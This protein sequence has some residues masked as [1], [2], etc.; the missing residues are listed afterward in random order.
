MKCPGCHSD[1]ADTSQF[2]SRCGAPLA[3]DGSVP[4]PRAR[5]LDPPP[6]TPRAD[7]L[8]AGKYRVLEEIGRGGMGVV[9]KAEDI[10]LKRPVALKFLPPQLADW[11]EFRERFLIEAQ[12]A[13]ALSHP[14]TCVIHEV[15]ETEERPFLAMEYVEGETLDA[16]IKRG[17]LEGKDIVAIIRQVAAGLGD[18]HRKGIVHRDIKSSNIMVTSDGQAKIMD[19]GLAK[20]RGG[21]AL[22]K[23]HTTLGT[24]TY[25]SPEQACGDEVDHRTDLWSA[26]VVLYEMLTGELPFQ[27]ESEVGV[28][29]RIVYEDP[30]PIRHRTPPVPSE[31]QQVVARA[32]KKNREA[33]YGSAEEIL[34]DLREYETARQAEAA[35]AFNLRR[36]VRRLR[37]PVVALPTALAVVAT[38]SLAVWYW[39]RRADIKWAREQAIPETERLIEENDVWR[40]LVPAYRLA[41]RAEKYIPRDPTLA[42]LF[43]RSS[44]KINVNTE[45]PGARVFIKEY[46][47]PDSTWELLGVSP[48]K[49]IRLPIGVFRWKLE[50][51]GYET[52]LAAAS[53][54]NVDVSAGGGIIPH[55]FV[56][57]LDK[58]GVLPPGMV[59]IPGATAAVGELG[60]FYIGRYEVTNREFKA[61]I[62]AGGYRRREWWKHEF[63]KGGRV[64]ALEEAIRE[65]VD[66]TGLPGPAGWQAGDYPEGQGNYPVSGVSWYEA[67]AYAEYAGKS[68]PT[69]AHWNMAR[70]AFTPI[71]KW[72]Q[73]GGM[74]IFAPFS[75]FNGIGPVPVGR[76]PSLTPYGTFDMPGN[77][78]EWCWNELRNGRVIMGGAWDDNPYMFG[79]RSQAPPLDRSTRNGFRLALYPNPEK[80]P[81][82]AFEARTLTQARDFYQETPV[83]ETIFHVYREQ[84]SYDATELNARVESRKES[85]AGWTSERISFDAAYGGERVIAHL[86]LPKDATPPYQTV[87]YFPGSQSLFGG[88]REHLDDWGEFRIFVSF[89]V[90]N[91]RAVLYPVY[92]GTFERGDAALASIHG[93]SGSRAYAEYL[94]QLVQDFRRSIDYLKTRPDIDGDKLAYYGMSWGAAL[95]AIIPAVEERIKTSVLLAGR[96]PVGRQA[97]RP[98][99]D[100]FNHVTRVR[101]PTL[102]LNGKYETLGGGLEGGI[103]PMFDLL[104]APA[105]DKQLI[106]YDTDHI[107]PRNEF[108]REILAWLD[109]YLGPVGS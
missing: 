104:G 1:N 28:I 56:R 106:L 87:V 65:F 57:A 90:K 93:G 51:D 105:K 91:G 86:F 60:D 46:A 9:Y 27:G 98:E 50:M 7:R 36:V 26:G 21:P 63:Q 5:T 38:A 84:F 40:N 70:G 44:L 29:E 42:E 100:P 32:L 12:A 22:T 23:S 35:S 20:R 97:R 52:V 99:A 13:A 89:L 55:D 48:L 64:L 80:I 43:T 41:Q 4:A 49:Q 61:F 19:F 82:A 34:T 83:P 109:R 24:V 79:N 59:R 8:I 53:T 67:A 31:L 15:G 33:R 102:M 71:I 66:Q 96:L 3:E 47:A 81:A 2:C 88:P 14:N 85:P 54:W 6:F 76:L 103:K 95:G 18:A 11:P 45:P 74:G 10:S 58:T 78:R 30:K 25:M 16:K 73:L 69:D 107:P 68:L 94:V 72:P 39:E 37:R 75:N 62:D 92:K 77:V 17:P 101:T 108:I